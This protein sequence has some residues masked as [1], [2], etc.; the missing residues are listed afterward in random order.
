MTKV[1]ANKPVNYTDVQVALIQARF[2]ANGG[3]LNFDDAKALA[4]DSRMNTEDGKERNPRSIVAKISRMGL[5]YKSQEPTTKTGD[6]IVKKS[7]LVAEIAKTVKG[8][9]EGLEKA[10]KPALLAIAAAVRKAA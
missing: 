8:N 2:E 6:P 1:P 5:K 9:L 10:P 3:I 7:D 4:A